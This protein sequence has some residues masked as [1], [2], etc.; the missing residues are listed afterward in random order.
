MNMIIV[1]FIVI[2]AVVVVW[3]PLIRVSYC[4]ARC[5]AMLRD[6]QRFVLGCD[7]SGDYSGQKCNRASRWRIA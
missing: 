2:L 7:Y 4:R 1:L 5:A 6:R 3:W